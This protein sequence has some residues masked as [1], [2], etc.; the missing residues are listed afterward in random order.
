MDKFKQS[1][2]VIKS[3]SLL[4]QGILQDYEFIREVRVFF[5]LIKNEPL[6]QSDLQFLLYIA[7]KSWIP[8]YF[9]FLEKFQNK[10]SLDINNIN[11][12][13]FWSF[14]HDS[15]LYVDDTQKL[16]KF[17]KEILNYFSKQKTNR[18]FISASTSF[19][20][21]FLVY[22]I[23]RK[24]NYKNIVLIFP[25]IALLIENY[26]KLLSDENYDFFKKQYRIHTL[27][28]VPES[29]VG[30]FNI[31]LFTPERFLSFLDQSLWNI[32]FDFWFIDEAYKIDNEYLDEEEL[33]ENERDTAYR[34]ATYWLLK[35]NPLIDLLM[36]WPYIT[37][38]EKEGNSF[39][40][41]VN[42][43]KIKVLDYNNYDIVQKTIILVDETFSKKD[44]DA[45]PKKDGRTLKRFW[46]TLE[47]VAKMDHQNWIICFCPRRSDTENLILWATSF[48]KIVCNLKTLDEEFLSFMD[49][50]KKNYNYNGEERILIKWLE[51]W[52][53]W[54]HGLIPKYIQKEIIHYFNKWII[55]ILFCT[56]TI[57]E[58][59]NTSAKNI[60]IY[61]A[62]KWDKDLKAFDAKNIQWRAGRFWHHYVWNVYVLDHEFE[63]AK[64][65]EENIKHKNYDKKSEK[66]NIDLFIT[67]NAYLN[68]DNFNKR[69]DIEEEYKKRWIDLSIINLYKWIDPLLKLK[70]FDLISALSEED[71]EEIK[72]WINNYN[73]LYL[74]NSFVKILHLIKEIVP[75]SLNF[76]FEVPQWKDKPRIYWMILAYLSTWFPG[77]V[78][79]LVDNLDRNI[80]RAIRETSKFIYTILKYQF[81]K[82]LWVFN[83]MF[84]VYI[85]QK[86]AKKMDDI[87]WLERLLRKLEYNALTDKWRRASD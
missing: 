24:M 46:P 20:K 77:S 58:W 80:N 56:T 55:K 40:E 51:R 38:D 1:L 33:K 14:F 74:D 84:K 48:W 61:K 13:S 52:I 18:F 22:E 50:L 41:F 29:E 8:H 23:M 63:R 21:T 65:H 60:I 28:D 66:D 62:K 35:N 53:W 83:I 78:K 27:S 36:A 75:P 69:N 32:G 59:V 85:A 15:S 10:D 57:T 71:I 70:I 64:E 87:T 39:Y 54:H 5:D 31:F 3:L 16:H 19:W 73:N 25:T 68:V 37:F 17:Q 2:N 7:N 30:E 9:D 26:E 49:H 82:Y 34:L 76:Y 43:N 67:D 42:K 11:L 86:E 6:S 45:W 72:S 12:L 79:Y 81:V 44:R 4:E 47:L